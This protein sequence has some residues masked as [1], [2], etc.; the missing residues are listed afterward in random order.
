MFALNVSVLPQLAAGIRRPWTVATPLPFA[1]VTGDVE[2]KTH[3]CDQSSNRLVLFLSGAHSYGHLVWHQIEPCWRSHAD[4]AV[5]TY[6]VDAF[7]AEAIAR[8]LADYIGKRYTNV[9]FVCASLGGLIAYDTLALL[10]RRF[11]DFHHTTFKLIDAPLRFANI[12]K[13]GAALIIGAEC[14]GMI[15]GTFNRLLHH[16]ES[17][18]ILGAVMS[19]NEVLLQLERQ[20]RRAFPVGTFRRQI[21][22]LREHPGVNS[23]V[24]QGS[25]ATFFRSQNDLL[26][27]DSAY[28]DWSQ[29]FGRSLHREFISNAGHVELVQKA[30]EY[31]SCLTY[32]GLRLTAA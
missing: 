24:L 20:A 23:Q 15:A 11:G 5:A 3:Y 28:N 10:R 16:T 8:S 32:E 9:T 31:E 21:N 30:R 1:P 18:P 27:T 14:G 19:E 26:V 6:N 29:A 13:K 7:D 12:S 17:V 25:D 4:T 22:Y 2:I